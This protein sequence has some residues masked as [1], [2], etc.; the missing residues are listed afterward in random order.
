M[1][2]LTLIIVSVFMFWITGTAQ[3]GETVRYFAKFP[4]VISPLLEFTPRGEV[5]E[6][7]AKSLN[8][9]VVRYDDHNRMTSMKYFNQQ[10][11]S[12]D[13]YFYAHEVRYTYT[14][15]KKVRE[16]FDTT[17]EPMA[18]SRHYYRSANVQKEEYILEGNKTTLH[19]YGV[20]GE[21]IEAGTG[22]YVFEGE[23][24]EGRG[25][26]QRLYRKDGSPGIIFEYLPFE[27][28]LL[29]LDQYGFIHQILNFDDTTGKVK[30]HERAGFAEMRIMFDKYG[31]E[32]GWDFRDV[33]GNKV[34]R[35]QEIVDGGHAL[36]TYDFKW[37]NRRLGQ[38]SG[39]TQTYFTADGKAFCRKK[40]VC[41]ETYQFNKRDNVTLVE[42]NGRSGELVVDPEQKFA[43]LE[44][45]Y[46][47]KGRRLENRYYGADAKLR[48]SGVAVRKWSYSSDGSQSVKSFD[49][50]GRELTDE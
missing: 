44:I 48:K 7:Q 46:D 12:S 4:G 45:D 27:V 1:K 43:R 10:E 24:L 25:L 18:M 23:K 40:I 47:E 8:H 38:Y 29:T 32:L 42:I 28:S 6:E 50:T 20:D 19:M 49:F 3:A 37:T 15:G 36:W 26:I 2:R 41:S 21:R 9:Y 35:S 14:H 16:Y 5:T 11:A 34:N 13:S 39:Y 22:T 30:M 17:G 33:A 31:N